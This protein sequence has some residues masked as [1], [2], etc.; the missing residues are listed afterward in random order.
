MV[1]NA[2]KCTTKKIA[3]TL[4]VKNTMVKDPKIEDV[5]NISEVFASF[6]AHV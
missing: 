1:A 3:V 2:K 4:L 5:K 6:F